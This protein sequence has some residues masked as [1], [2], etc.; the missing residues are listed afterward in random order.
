MVYQ[1]NKRVGRILFLLP[2]LLLV[3]PLGMA[4]DTL[5]AENCR[6]LPISCS[7][8]DKQTKNM[9]RED[10]K[11]LVLQGW[12]AEESD[13]QA[14]LEQAMQLKA[15]A[16]RAKDLETRFQRR[17]SELTSTI[18]KISLLE[19]EVPKAEGELASAKERL[20]AVSGVEES[21]KALEGNLK[22]A[23]VSF[24]GAL[25]LKTRLETQ[26]ADCKKQVS[27]FEMRVAEKNASIA[28]LNGIR[29][30]R[31]WVEEHFIPSLAKIESIVL[32]SLNREF[33]LMFKK[34]F[35]LLVESQD[36]SVSV[37]SQ[38]E[39]LVQIGEYE[40]PHTSLSGGEK[41]ALALAYRLS[42]NAIVKSVSVS[43]ND[44]LLILDEPTD[45]FSKEQLARL[46][47]VLEELDS[48]QVLLVSHERELEAFADKVFRIE[49][50][51][52]A[53]VIS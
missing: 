7:Y 50:K 8:L 4:I 24:N 32:E 29:E 52:G 48:K 28:K 44:N 53:S 37:G 31:K 9:S 14:L 25:A 6:N 23:E 35:M 3:L 40:H 2:A 19:P 41:S 12:R 16:E 5:T 45:G 34:W 47:R 38:F 18:Q 46:K 13:L 33:D 1:L 39:P 42:L 15:M 36:I 43:M 10:E 51:G 27:S 26:S 17:N 20:S 49:K 21:A 11:Q 22:A 30:R